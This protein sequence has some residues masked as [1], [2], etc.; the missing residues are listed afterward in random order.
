LNQINSNSEKSNY[1][2]ELGKIGRPHGVRGDVR[3]FLHNPDSELIFS[4]DNLTLSSP[5]GH[6]SATYSIRTV[7]D[8]ARFLILSLKDVRNREQAQLLNGMVAKVPRELLPSLDDG[9]FYVADLIG[10]N[11]VCDGVSVGVITDSRAQGGIEV[12]TVENDVREIQ[13]PV[14]DEYVVR[15]DVPA[16]IFEVRN[17]EDLPTHEIIRK[18]L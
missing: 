13:I 9:E 3:F 15:K 14:V 8:G 7:K 2:V 11:V 17:I 12:I 10:V 4:L 18:G 5:D 1:Y 6:N 16:G